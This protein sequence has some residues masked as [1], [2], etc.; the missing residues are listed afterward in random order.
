MRPHEVHFTNVP[1]GLQLILKGAPTVILAI[2]SRDVDALVMEFVP[3]SRAPKTPINAE[4]FLK[5]GS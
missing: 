5:N 4:S 2:R 1:E 3:S